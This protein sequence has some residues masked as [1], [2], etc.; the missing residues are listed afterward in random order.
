M[1]IIPFKFWFCSQDNTIK[2]KYVIFNCLFCKSIEKSC[3]LFNA[4]IQYKLI[5]HN[6]MVSSIPIKYK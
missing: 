1:A 3:E 4:K 5:A 2:F 6:Y